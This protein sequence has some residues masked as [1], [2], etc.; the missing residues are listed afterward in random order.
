MLFPPLLVFASIFSACCL[1]TSTLGATLA[2]DE[3]EALESIGETLGKTNWK[4]SVDPCSSGDESWAKFAEKGA[5][6]SA[7]GTKSIRHSP[8]TVDQTSL[9]ARNASSIPEE[10]AN[11][12]NLTSLVLEHNNFSGNLPAA[13]GNLPKI[14]IFFLNSNNFIGEL[15]ETFARLTTLKEFRIGDNN[16]TGKIPGFIFQNWTNLTDM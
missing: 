10:L 14:E 8:T 13:L 15:P 7:E 16:F 12:S 2:K 6:Y 11:I 4:F 3:V 1:A 9:P 5:Y